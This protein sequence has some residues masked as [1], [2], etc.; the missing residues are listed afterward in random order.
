MKDAAPITFVNT[1]AVSGHNN[2]VVN[3]AFSTA[4]F[5][6]KQDGEQT[7]VAIDEFISSNLRMDLFCAQQLH[8]SLGKILAQ[9][10][11]P[12]PQGMN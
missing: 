10:T 1:L 12:N 8:D 7:I 2:G 9:Q 4:S 6:P 5:V 11:K 3:L